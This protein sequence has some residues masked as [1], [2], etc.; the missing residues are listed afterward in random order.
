MDR[1]HASVQVGAHQR[2]GYQTL[3][4]GKEVLWKQAHFL[5]PKCSSTFFIPV[6][7]RVAVDICIRGQLKT[8]KYL[9]GGLTHQLLCLLNSFIKFF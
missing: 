2:T 7:L 8:T 5:I 3:I 4:H 6:P 1:G 9:S